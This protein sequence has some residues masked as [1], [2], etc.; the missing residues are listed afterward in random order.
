VLSGGYDF[1][2]VLKNDFGQKRN[3]GGLHVQLALRLRFMRKGAT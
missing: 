2:P 1:A 3:D